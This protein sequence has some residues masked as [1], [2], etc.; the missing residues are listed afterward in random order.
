MKKI[1]FWALVAYLF[2]TGS[3]LAFAF[4]EEECKTRGGECWADP[5]GNS[6]NTI[7][8]CFGEGVNNRINCCGNATNAQKIGGGST[9]GSQSLNFKEKIQ[10]VSTIQEFLTSAQGYLNA[11][12]GT[13]AIVFILIGAALYI[14]SAFGK[15]DM[16][17]L[18]KKIVIVAV[19]GFTIV[20][21]API[22]F[23]EIVNLVE[24]SPENIVTQSGVVKILNGVVMGFLGFVGMYAIIS[25]LFGGFAYFFAGGDEKRAERGKTIVT[26]AIIGVAIVVGAMIIAKQIVSLLGG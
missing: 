11:V 14:I 15:E 10:T 25:F 16:A 7:G 20:V 17:A 8:T 4:T 1:F 5:C 12:A 3:F 18:G 22:I 23:K 19:G 26:Y 21:A 6:G 9:S 24:G 2:F 13:I